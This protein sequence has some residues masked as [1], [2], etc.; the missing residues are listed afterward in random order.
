METEIRYSWVGL[1]WRADHV[2]GFEKKVCENNK[3]PSITG[4]SPDRWAGKSHS[5]ATVTLQMEQ[6]AECRD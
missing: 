3:E 1:Y 6:K 5:G 4:Q 2:V